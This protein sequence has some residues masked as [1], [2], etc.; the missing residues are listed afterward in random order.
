MK[1][2]LALT[3]AML[4]SVQTV[5]AQM[6]FSPAV[7]AQETETPQPATKVY[8]VPVHNLTFRERVGVRVRAVRHAAWNGVKK[9]GRGIVRVNNDPRVQNAVSVASTVMTAAGAYYFVRSSVKPA[10]KL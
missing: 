6:I 3:I 9:L 2:A 1:F 5:Q 4:L 7:L 8:L 10:P